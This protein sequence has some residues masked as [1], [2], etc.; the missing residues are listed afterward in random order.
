MPNHKEI[1]NKAIHQRKNKISFLFL[2]LLLAMGI[3]LFSV[4]K[5]ISS[6]R[7]IPSHH[8][9][10]HDR[11]FRG[12][13]ISAD[14]YTL[15]SSQKTYQ[16]V[17]RGASIDPDKKA[18]FVKLFSIYSGI[19]EKKILKRFKNRKGKEIKGNI[20]LSKTINARSA[21]QL[22]SLAYK[23]RKLDVFQS[24]KTRSGIEVVY[25]LDIIENGESRRFPLGDVLSPIL[26]YVGKKSDGKYTRPSGKK[27]LERSYEKHIT[28]KKNGYFQG[29]RDVVGAVIHDKN[30]IKIQRVDGLDL[31]LN[32]P[33]ALQRRIELMID[34][35]KLSIDADEI[36]VGVI[37]SNTGK[38]LSLA[39]TERYDPSHIRQKDIAALVPKFTE[40]PYEA[41][42]VLKPI[43]LAIAID[44]KKVTPDTWFNT[45]NGR[46]QIGKRHWITDD[47][48]FE[49]LTA[50]DII[51]HSSNVGISQ[52]AWKLTGEEFRD[53]L[54]KFGVA[55]KTGIDL[56]RDLPGQLKPVRLLNHQL[57]LAN[58]SYGYGMM[59]TF[60]QL[61]KA[62]SAFNNDGLA[63][64]P[65]IVDY[66]QDAKG[67]H[68]TLEPKIGDVQAVSK[69]TANQ[70]KTILKEVV[71]RGTG[72]KAQYPGLEV[73]GKT[74]TAHIAKKG[75]YVREYHSSFYGFAND[76]EGHKYTIGAL[77]IRAKKRYKYFAS[78]SAVPTFRRMMDILVELD[79]LKPEGGLEITSPE[80][81]VEPKIIP[82]VTPQPIVEQ[83]KKVEKIIV[84]PVSKPKTSVK[85]LFNLK[86]AKAVEPKPL[87]TTPAK[88]KSTQ[89]LFEDLF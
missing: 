52:I 53:G 64:S 25:G 63:M 27:G 73:G 45:Y 39:S 26:G 82:K 12:S 40:Y 44:H 80:I 28:S 43:S 18:L 89:E 66:L 22:K 55:K 19:P 2:L 20:T 86:P 47:E 16:A 13:I 70:I 41:G 24:I 42:S 62:Y 48:K 87:K 71:A 3:F 1:Q 35:M 4:L 6:D 69:K 5:T 85:E 77:V 81:K 10:I 72:V 61:M 54:L 75:R 23:L 59:I 34:Q 21:M 29:K 88:D 68:Y 51:V 9:T 11:S 67:N 74:G 65:R 84:K 14:G 60:A 37:E 31:H 50:T 32:I 79:Y 36:I 46:L 58:T 33:L 17:I 76:K 49:S 78:Q 7:R 57:H 38:V 8:S 83:Q 15:S 30:S 56:S